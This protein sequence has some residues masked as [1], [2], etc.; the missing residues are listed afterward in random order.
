MDLL[1][2]CSAMCNVTVATRL[3]TVLAKFLTPAIFLRV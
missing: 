2:Q 1:G 3:C